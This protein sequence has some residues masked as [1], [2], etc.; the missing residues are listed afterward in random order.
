[1]KGRGGK[2]PRVIA[3]TAG[4]GPEGHARAKKEAKGANPTSLEGGGRETGRPCRRP[5][6][7]RLLLEE[8]KSKLSITGGG[9]GRNPP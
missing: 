3:K 1:V 5:N 9:G 2:P 8:E 7:P 6:G 4:G